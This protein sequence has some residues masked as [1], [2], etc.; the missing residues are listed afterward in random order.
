MQRTNTR[1][2]VQ[3]TESVMPPLFILGMHRLF[4]RRGAGRIVR[5]M[6]GLRNPKPEVHL[7]TTEGNCCCAPVMWCHFLF[8]T[9]KPARL[10]A[11][12]SWPGH[13]LLPG[14]SKHEATSS[15]NIVFVFDYSLLQICA[16][17]LFG[18]MSDVLQDFIFYPNIKFIWIIIT[19]NCH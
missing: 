3:G 2:R 19:I 10:Q 11:S 14:T 8:P 6:S 9:L 1:S 16:L 12:V 4:W 13:G 5:N 15:L 7:T 17:L 18:D